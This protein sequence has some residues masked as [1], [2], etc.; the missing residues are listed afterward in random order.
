MTRSSITSWV[1][2][3]S[4]AAEDIRPFVTPVDFSPGAH[5]GSEQDGFS[6]GLR[7]IQ[8][9]GLWG[10]VDETGETVV[11]AEYASIAYSPVGDAALLSDGSLYYNVLSDYAL[12]PW[13]SPE[14][15]NSQF[16]WNHYDNALWLF[17]YDSGLYY[18]GPLFTDA[19]LPVLEGAVNPN[20]LLGVDLETAGFMDSPHFRPEAWDIDISAAQCW[21]VPPASE[22]V[23]MGE[24]ISE[25]LLGYADGSALYVEAQYTRAQ[26]PVDGIAAVFQDGTWAYIDT[27]TGNKIHA[28]AYQDADL[29]IYFLFESMGE[30]APPEFVTRYAYNFSEGLA[31]VCRD[32]RWGYIDTKGNEVVSCQYDATRPVHNGLAWVCVDGLWGL[33]D[34][35]DYIK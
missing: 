7:A 22:D 29:S 16:F 18:Y 33:A 6:L 21:T 12:S 14:Q 13:M 15:H 11:P 26:Y 35:S 1:V 27:A 10:A 24:R 17:V 9:D 32:G 19:V 2:E 31:A 8:Q 4:L 23:P 30:D 28:A 20:V 25:P 34:L 3:P 5:P